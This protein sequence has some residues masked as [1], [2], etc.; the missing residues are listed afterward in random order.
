MLDLKT[1]E[2]RVTTP[3]EFSVELETSAGSISVGDLKGEV[4]GRTS[5]GS[6]RFGKI[7]GP[8]RGRTSGGS[9]TLGG[10]LGRAPG[11]EEGACSAPAVERTLQCR[12]HADRVVGGGEEYAAA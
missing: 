4:N 6:L 8:V 12:R 11:G 5:G 10:T 1:L 2:Y 7:D 3:R 9:I